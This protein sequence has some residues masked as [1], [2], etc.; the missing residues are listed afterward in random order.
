MHDINFLSHYFPAPKFLDTPYVG[1]DISPL[2]VRMME[3]IDRPS[4]RVGNYAEAP[5]QNPFAITEGAS[6]EVKDI[7]K[8]WKKEYKLEY[9]K[10]SLPE[11][12]AYLFDTEVEFGSEEKMRNAIEFSLEENV[13]LSGKDVLF[14]Y[15]LIGESEKKGFIKVA[16]TVLPSQVIDAY[17]ALFRE[18]GLEP[19]SF[20]IEAQAVSRALIGRGDKG[21]YLMVNIG[22]TRTGVF[23]ASNGAVQFTSTVPIGSSDFTMALQNQLSLEE[24]AAE[25]LKEKKGL[26][27]TDNNEALAPLLGVAQQFRE[28]IEKVYVYW[29]KHHATPDAITSIQKVIVCGREALTPG[30]K[31]YLNQ[32]LKLP[33][34]TGNVW[35]N[36]ASFDEYVPPLPLAHALN[37]S[38]AIGLALPENE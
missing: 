15:R 19:I 37:F 18:C 36:F 35:T 20:L 38:A 25:I 26:I 2:A 29:N 7:L 27:R 28:E 4:R 21:T 30:F 8:K 12:K 24:S 33:I 6:T 9:V 3:I 1:I 34:E 31:E 5:L 11:E 22:K 32:A 13:P 17:H 16:V 14:D 23:I 10:A